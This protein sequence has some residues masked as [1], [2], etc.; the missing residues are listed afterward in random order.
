MPLW[1]TAC[2]AQSRFQI[3]LSSQNLHG[4]FSPSGHLT[5]GQGSDFAKH[6]LCARYFNNPTA[7]GG[8]CNY[9]Y[10]TGEE[11]EA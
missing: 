9:P 4:L 6:L 5:Q 1:E 8:T 7:L 3:L 10:L 2:L 11:T